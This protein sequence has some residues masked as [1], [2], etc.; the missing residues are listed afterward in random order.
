MRTLFSV[1]LFTC[2]TAAG[3]VVH[4]DKA[5]AAVDKIV[6]KALPAIVAGANEWMADNDCVSCHRVTYAA[7][8]LNLAVDS[9]ADVTEKQRKQ[10]NQWSTDWTK[11]ANPKVRAE[12][13]QESTLK[14]DADTVAQAL[15]GVAAVQNQYNEEWAST[16][17]A[18]MIIGQQDAGFWK[19]GGQLPLQKRPLQE[20]QEVTTMWALVALNSSKLSDPNGDSVKKKAAVWLLSKDR[21]SAGKSIEWWALKSLLAEPFHNASDQNSALAKLV[22][23]QN[24]D[25]GWGWL[26]NEESDALGTGI[27]LYSLAGHSSTDA[28]KARIQAIEFLQTS[29]L[30]DGGWDVRGTKKSG[31]D[32][33]V[34]TASYWGT[35]WAVIGLLQHDKSIPA[36]PSK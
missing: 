35:C 36:G 22:S 17:H 33:V 25:G 21:V 26:I 8:A 4:A 34:E 11:V 24:A 16:Y 10:I 6:K 30:P 31:R 29:Q 18:S 2:C 1:V 15:L 3:N 27:A 20:T 9:D 23:F 28:D 32:D 19:P 12:A 7:W 5:E 14:N 13:E